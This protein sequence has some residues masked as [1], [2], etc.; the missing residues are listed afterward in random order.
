M[1][2]SID[3]IPKDHL[4][5]RAVQK[6]IAGW[7]AI[8][9]AVILSV[10][11]VAFSFQAKVGALDSQ[12]EPLRQQ[13]LAMAAWEQKLA[14]LAGELET[15]R[16]RQRVVENLLNEPSW[17]GLLGDLASATGR[18][19][20]LTQATAMKESVSDGEE[21]E[22][23]ATVV[24][25]SGMSSSSLELM[26]FMTRLGHSRH[27]SALTLEKSMVSRHEDTSEMIGFELRI[28]VQVQT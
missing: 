14:P 17:S 3:L 26:R 10:V 11:L 2:H 18:G 13:V 6:R 28:V 9:T 16:E 19:L 7:V 21:D 20:W 24:A 12:V 8:A 4:V 1:G 15:A 23:E 22:H 5:R 25:I 27:V